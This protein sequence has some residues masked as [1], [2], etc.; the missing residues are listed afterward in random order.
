MLR[1]LRDA[2]GALGC[3][4][5]AAMLRVPQD[6][7]GISS[8][9]TE[10]RVGGSAA[11]SALAEGRKVTGN[12]GQLAGAAGCDCA[13]DRMRDIGEGL[14]AP[15]SA[16]PLPPETS[17]QHRAAAERCCLPV[18]SP[19]V[20]RWP[21]AR[22]GV[23]GRG[24]GARERVQPPVPERAPSTRRTGQSPAEMSGHWHRPGDKSQP[25]A[26]RG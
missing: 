4:E 17:P 1:V 20:Q 5:C 2:L 7:R 23:A 11:P 15:R 19:A 8:P 24:Q 13:G 12:L 18:H 16:S 22:A 26:G 6:V 10:T 9:R 3:S 14:V 25:L 21:W